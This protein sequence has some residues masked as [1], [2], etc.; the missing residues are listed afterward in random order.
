MER[1]IETI[2]QR[3][4]TL[5]ETILTKEQELSKAPNG[6]V[7]VAKSGNRVQFY[8][9]KEASDRDRKYL[10]NKD[11]QLVK[12]LC[13]KDYDQKVLLAASKELEE[14]EYLK[15]NY[16]KETFEDVYNKINICRKE[17]VHPVILSDEAFVANWEQIEYE[18]KSFREET[19]EYYTDK[20]ER[21]RSK[22]EILIANALK[23]HNIPYRYECPLYLKGYGTIHPDFTV[24]N[25][26]LRKEFY[27][28]HMGMV[29]N[30]SY[31]EEAFHRIDMYEKNNIFPGDKLILSH[32]S[33]KYPINTRSVE[34]LIYQYLK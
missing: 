6:I 24:L 1:F 34:K 29:D 3:I 23:K 11:K 16:P 5:K 28:E 14:L 18:R 30:S 2:N 8:Y 31:L 21:V 26:R 22:S 25:V 19:P 13:Q 12:R 33:L 20:G 15:N 17:F 7:N 10:R 9:K 32:E 4:I 27:W